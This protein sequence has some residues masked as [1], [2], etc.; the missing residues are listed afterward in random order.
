MSEPFHKRFDIEVSVE[1][2]R[3]RFVNRIRIGTKDAA[4]KALSE[5]FYPDQLMEAIRT[6]P[7]LKLGFVKTQ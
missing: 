4:G 1:E 5:N 2:V 7:T 3:R 6:V